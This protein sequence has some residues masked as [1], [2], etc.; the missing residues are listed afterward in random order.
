MA[1]EERG[2]GEGEEVGKHTTR[3]LKRPQGASTARPGRGFTPYQ[4]TRKDSGDEGMASSKCLPHDVMLSAN[5]QRVHF[6]RLR[7]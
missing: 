5:F 6:A 3:L 1:C 2:E 4:D 7:H